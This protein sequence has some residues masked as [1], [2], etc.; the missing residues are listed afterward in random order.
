MIRRRNTRFTPNG[1]RFSPEV[2]AQIHNSW[3]ALD[4]DRNVSGRVACRLNILENLGNR[5]SGLIVGKR[6]Y[7]CIDFGLS[8][9]FIFAEGLVVKDG[10]VEL[11][12]GRSN[13]KVK[14]L[15]PK[16]NEVRS[17]KCTEERTIQG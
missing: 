15:V 17:K 16:A 1:N 2:E 4:L 8:Q 13:G 14:G 7:T 6:I 12:S 10:N 9:R 11:R 5:H 3:A